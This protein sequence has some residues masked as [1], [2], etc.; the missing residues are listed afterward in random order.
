MY[1]IRIIKNT[2]DSNTLESDL[3]NKEKWCTTWNTKIE[4]K[5]CKQCT[6]LIKLP[7]KSRGKTYSLY[8]HLEEPAKYA[9]SKVIVISSDFKSNNACISSN[10]NRILGSLRH[11]FRYCSLDMRKIIHLQF[12][13]EI[14]KHGCTVWSPSTKVVKGKVEPM[15]NHRANLFLTSINSAHDQCAD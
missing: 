8:K 3:N 13:R 9:T 14:T 6:F 2:D 11:N 12:I 10:A 7:H 4:I 15:Q 5:K 1:Y